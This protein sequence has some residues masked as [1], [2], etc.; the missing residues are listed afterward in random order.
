MEKY[1]DASLSPRER[2]ED[3]L[4]RMSIEEK[5]AQLQCVLVPIGREAAAGAYLTWGIG[6]ISTL[7]V[8]MLETTEEAAAFVNTLQEA[9]MANSP[10]H[11]PATFHM[12]GL[13]GAF[14]QDA[15]SFPSGIGRASGWDPALEEKI[16]EIVA[17]QETAAGITRT[18]APVLDISRDS[19]LGRQGETYGEDPTVA[20]ALGTAY[21]KGLQGA[22]AGGR[23]A[24]GTAKHFAGFHNSLGGIHG[25]ASN[26]PP[27]L[28]EEIY[29][30]PFQ[31]AIRDAE[32]RG[33]MPCYCSFDGE[34]ASCSH[35]LLTEVLRDEM[36]FDGVVFSDYS[37]IENIHTVQKMFETVTD[38][39]LAA[40]SAG[41]D[42][43]APIRAGFN[44]ELTEWFR[45]GKADMAILDNAVRRNLES[46]FRMGLFEHPFALT[47]E[48]LTEAFLDE[49]DAAVTLQS[50]RES[51]ILLKNDGT[52]PLAVAGSAPAG[53]K[54]VEKIAVVGT[55]AANARIFF[56]GYTHLSMVEANHAVANSIAG[57]GE[58]GAHSDRK[59]PL[60]PG[61]QIQSDET[62]EFAEILRKLKPGCRS[63]LEELAVRFP[64]AEISYSYG[65]AIAGDD[66]SHHE[67]ALAAVREADVCILTLGGKHGS[68]SVAS[69]GEGVDSTDIN[70][71]AC[72]ESFLRKAAETGTPLIGVHF[73]GR[74]ISSDAADE[75]L[76]AIIEAWNPSEAGAQAIVDVLDGTVNPS[77]KLPVSVAYSAGQIPVYYNHPNGSMWHQGESIGFANYV[78]MPHTP[79][80]AFG[81][82]LSYTTFSYDGFV[83]DRSAVGPEE[84]FHVSVNVTNNGAVPGTE[85]VQLYLKDVYASMTRPER[86]LGGFARVDLA[87][88]ETKTVTFACEPSQLAFLTREMEWKIEKGMIQVM[89]GKDSD[90]IVCSGSLQVT[91]DRMIEGRD[92]RFYA[93][94]A[95]SYAEG[96]ARGITPFNVNF[97]R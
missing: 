15:V 65:Y 87:P 72:Q 9:I 28:L 64:E 37:A 56:G 34:A 7:E 95:D 45:T 47:G 6:E 94:A 11:I 2:A 42:L 5:M 23:H 55:Q 59:V 19:R 86:E 93:E 17:R 25:A 40:M 90:A 85:I 96:V 60:V 83:I 14:L 36:G 52:L 22:S 32:L 30:K 77:G 49:G 58:A 29:A 13:C 68:C 21:T 70:L 88:G 82:G 69:M 33:V 53:P 74:P 73:D 79:R 84:E 81:Y 18:L 20:A 78:D 41:M 16:G 12:E 39:G 3:L 43:E 61:T 26:T 24:E 27:R 57:I 54:T 8:R 66:E 4:S 71:P 97:S 76:S 50:A 31:A 75:C 92:R 51:L 91:D 80:Y 46:K 63:L 67:E 44:D 1:L 89:I 38:A 62:E 48:A 10:H 35:W